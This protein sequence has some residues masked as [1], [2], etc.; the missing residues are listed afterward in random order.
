[1]HELGVIIEV[2]KQIEQFAKE[3]QLE[4][5]IAVLTLQIGELSSM[6]PKYMM[7]LY[8]AAV[9]GTILADSRLEVEVIPGNG[10]CKDCDTI[11]HLLSNHG[12]CPTCQSDRFLLLSG[13][14]FMI[15]EII[16]KENE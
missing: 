13:K 14:E 1:M 7:E 4:E 12:K 8:P 5:P 3:E 15:K 11:F 9:E 2:V 6:I 16:I 10:K